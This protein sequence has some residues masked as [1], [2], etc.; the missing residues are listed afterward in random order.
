MEFYST[1]GEGPVSGARAIINGI[2][3]D[4]GLYVPAEFPVI[5]QEELEDMV[6]LE[7]PE[8]AA[9]ILNKYLTEFSYEELLSYT[10]KEQR[11]MRSGGI[12]LR[13]MPYFLLTKS[14]M[15]PS[16]RI[17]EKGALDRRS[18]AYITG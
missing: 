14:P 1:R 9:Y 5:T 3:K 6:G 7:Y 12:I 15:S 18:K 8:R 4:G 10:E 16:K 13:G 17:C 11:N 2:A